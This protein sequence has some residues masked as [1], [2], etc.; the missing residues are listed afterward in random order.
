[1]A[2]WKKN[3]DSILLALL[4]TVCFGF[5]KMLILILIISFIY[6]YNFLLT[7]LIEMK[8]CR[9][10][11]TNVIETLNFELSH[12]IE[13]SA[14]Q[15]CALFTPIWSRFYLCSLWWWT[16][17]PPP[18]WYWAPAPDHKSTLPSKCWRL[19]G[20]PVVILFLKTYQTFNWQMESG[21]V[22]LRGQNVTLRTNKMIINNIFQTQFRL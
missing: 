15:K 12:I 17:P 8:K 13:I 7:P 11:M 6:F 20:Q 10:V 18:W 19:T 16:P 22:L 9:H 2:G 4:W 14:R 3:Y 5:E 1:M 21:T